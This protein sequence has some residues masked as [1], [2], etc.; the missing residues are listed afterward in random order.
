VRLSFSYPLGVI[1]KSEVPNEL[2]RLL[3]VPT[4][5]RVHR[6]FAFIGLVTPISC[7]GALSNGLTIRPVRYSLYST[8]LVPLR[9]TVGSGLYSTLLLSCS[10]R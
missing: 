10:S 5:I 6:D 2:E 9:R 3:S 7:S 4:L 8:K 1:G